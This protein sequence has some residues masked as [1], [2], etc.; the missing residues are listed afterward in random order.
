MRAIGFY[1]LC[2][3]F[4]PSFLSCFFTLIFSTLLP[5]YYLSL[6]YFYSRKHWY[7]KHSLKNSLAIPRAFVTSLTCPTL[8]LTLPFR[9]SSVCSCTHTYVPIPIYY[10]QFIHNSYVHDS[11]MIRMCVIHN[12]L[13]I[14]Y[15]TSIIHHHPFYFFYFSRR[16][17]PLPPFKNPLV[18]LKSPQ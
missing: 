11:Y 15:P 1:I 17:L 12:S 6:L 4:C 5:L 14:K 7:S 8:L 2:F 3:I 9:I 18:K 16:R 13:F 10:S